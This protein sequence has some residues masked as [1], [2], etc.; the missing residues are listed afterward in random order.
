M[1]GIDGGLGLHTESGSTNVQSQP[2]NTTFDNNSRTTFVLH[3]GVLFALASIGHFSFQVTPELDIGFGS[4]TNPVAPSAFNTDLSGFLLQVGARGGAEI[5]FGFIGV[6]QLAMDA[7][8]GLFLQSTTNKTSTGPG[9][10]KVSTLAINTTNVFQPW[11]I[12]QGNVA[13]RY[14]F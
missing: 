2:P 11:N 6:P 5:Q 3:A 1:I 12:F 7:S 9:S 8:V 13:V 10:T 4:G 14:Y